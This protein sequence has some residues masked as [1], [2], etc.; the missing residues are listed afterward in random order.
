MEVFGLT[1]H[2]MDSIIAS[3]RKLCFR[4]SKKRQIS[5]LTRLRCHNL[6]KKHHKYL[7]ILTHG[8]PFAWL[9]NKC[10][11][12]DLFCFSETTFHLYPGSMYKMMTSN[13][14][15]PVQQSPVCKGK[16]HYIYKKISTLLIK[17]YGPQT[18]N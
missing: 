5:Q 6:E 11:Q 17:L 3:C 9:Q 10:R 4:F 16:S 18:T 2:V 13:A 7:L 1:A 8:G 12:M 14:H 15:W